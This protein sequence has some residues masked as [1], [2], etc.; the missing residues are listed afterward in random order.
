MVKKNLALTVF[1]CLL[2]GLIGN[3]ALS[4]ENS[5]SPSHSSPSLWESIVKIKVY[6]E[7]SD[8]LLAFL[9]TEEQVPI[10]NKLSLPA[11]EIVVSHVELN[12]SQLTTGSNN[13]SLL[14]L[15][16]QLNSQQTLVLIKSQI[17]PE[18]ITETVQ[19]PKRV[20]VK[21]HY[22][23][24][25]YVRGYYRK[26][27]TYVRGHYRRGG[28]VRGHWRTIGTET[29]TRTIKK[30]PYALTPELLNDLIFKILDV[31]Y[32]AEESD[33]E[34]QSQIESLKEFVEKLESNRAKE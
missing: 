3:L 28:S 33:Q 16:K 8:A 24:G 18:Y 4:D 19:R 27:G 2:V 17:R 26:N 9:S 5:A 12:L 25:T 30:Y 32:K 6:P 21:G 1:I 34:V 31:K 14:V 11:F 22:R 23:K 13:I 10:N 29:T 20:W 15:L 7:P